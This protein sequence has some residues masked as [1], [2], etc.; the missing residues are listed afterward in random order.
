M[1]LNFLLISQNINSNSIKGY[2]RFYLFKEEMKPN[3][4]SSE[5]FDFQLNILKNVAIKK[6]FKNKKFY[7]NFYYRKIIYISKTNK[8]SFNGYKA[9]ATKLLKLIFISLDFL[10]T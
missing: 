3:I 5:E 1:L 7:F 2:Y 9:F 8:Q 10:Q 4:F 6:Y